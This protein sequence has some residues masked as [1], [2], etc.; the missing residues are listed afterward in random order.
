MYFMEPQTLQVNSHVTKKMDKS[1]IMCK[2]QCFKVSSE[3]STCK[4]QYLTRITHFANFTSKW[5]NGLYTNNNGMQT[6]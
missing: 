6:N 5:T 2:I 4:K 1:K 3:E